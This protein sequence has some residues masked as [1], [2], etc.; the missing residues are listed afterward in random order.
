MTERPSQWVFDLVIQLALIV[1]LATLAVGLTAGASPLVALL[2][3]GVAFVAIVLV[4]W[5]L[6]LVFDVPPPEAEEADE[7][8]DSQ[9]TSDFQTSESSSSGT[10]NRVLAAENER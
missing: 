10:S 7:Q 5:A 8:S 6:S 2:R 3:S 1:C 9:S 4:G